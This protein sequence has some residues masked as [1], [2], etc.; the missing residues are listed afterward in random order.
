M[1]RKANLIVNGSKREV[2][3]E[4]GATLLEVLRDHLGLTGTKEGCSKGDCGACT[5]LLA[6]RAV[7]ACLTPVEKAL[8]KEIVTIEGLGSEE[9][10]HPMQQAFI[11]AG[12]VQCGYCIPG[13]IMS[14][15]GLRRHNPKPD[16][17][18]IKEAIAGNLC[19][20]TGYKKIIEAVAQGCEGKD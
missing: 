15:E 13:M 5:V 1:E 2:S 10:L 6:D 7:L 20:C 19:R 16:M 18:E 14:G 3:F 8:G 9:K 4:P 17:E 12:A 11:D